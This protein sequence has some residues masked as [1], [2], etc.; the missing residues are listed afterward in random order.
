[1]DDGTNIS[2][3][4]RWGSILIGGGLV[5]RGMRRGSVG[6]V[7]VAALGAGLLERGLSGRCR[8]YHALGVD[9]SGERGTLVMSDSVQVNVSPETCYQAWRDLEG[10]PRFLSHVES[11][12]VGPDGYSHWTA[13][14]AGV[15]VSWDAKILQDHPGRIL[16]WRSLPGSVV[17]TAGL[18]RFEELPGGRG[19]G[20]RVEIAYR[21]RA[22][23][24]GRAVARLLTPAV[25]LQLH[26][27]VRRFKRMLEA[28]EIATTEG[29]TSGRLEL[30]EVQ[31]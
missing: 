18:V 3:V 10:L 14:F 16:S 12:R 20:L 29:Q 21:A 8:L 9:A 13:T 1:M 24:M 2:D 6:G 7:A 22:G 17:E 30:Q 5:W 25:R 4:E 19:T 15:V 11:V 26:E 28:R 23:A 27:D 31:P